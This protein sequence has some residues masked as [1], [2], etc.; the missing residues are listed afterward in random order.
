VGFFLAPN[1][2]S[3]VSDINVLTLIQGKIHK[4]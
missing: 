2:L 4:F 3:Q 1:I